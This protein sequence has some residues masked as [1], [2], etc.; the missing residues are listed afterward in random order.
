[1]LCVYLKLPLAG[2]LLILVRLKERL[3]I[4]DAISS[5]SLNHLV[6]LGLNKRFPDECSI[7]M[8]EVDAIKLACQKEV[9][10]QHKKAQDQLN[11]DT[12]QTE[13]T[14]R[15][16]VINAVFSSYPCVLLSLSLFLVLR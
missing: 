15:F 5:K 1:M 9:D 2:F 8:K 3:Q 7:W 11:A 6:Q 14:I 12:A 16:A 10:A 4:S 13:S